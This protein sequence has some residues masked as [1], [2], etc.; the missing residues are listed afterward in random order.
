MCE[1]LSELVQVVEG[2]LKEGI[3]AEVQGVEAIH[4]VRWNMTSPRAA[5][6]AGA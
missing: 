5:A 2:G 3:G 4:P 6:P 1:L